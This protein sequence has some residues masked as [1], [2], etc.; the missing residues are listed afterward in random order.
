MQKAAADL[1]KGK[2]EVVQGQVRLDVE[3]AGRAGVKYSMWLLN[4]KFSLTKQEFLALHNGERYR[5]YYAPNTH[6]ILSVAKIEE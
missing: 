2:V 5:I 4:Q 6:L 3:S 1:Y